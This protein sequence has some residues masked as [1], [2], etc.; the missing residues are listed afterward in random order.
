MYMRSWSGGLVCVMRIGELL[1]GYHSVE[2]GLAEYTH[3]HIHIH[4]Q[5]Y[6]EY[7]GSGEVNELKLKSAPV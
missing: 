2:S 6:R 5:V 1:A 7:T 3:T 4:M